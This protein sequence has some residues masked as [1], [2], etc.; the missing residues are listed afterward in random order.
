MGHL[1]IKPFKCTKCEF[2]TVTATNVRTH[3]RKS[4]LK[5][6]PYACDQC[7]KRFV[8]GVLL[9]EHL[10]THTG[11]RPFKCQICNFACASRQVLSCHKTTHKSNKVSRDI[12]INAFTFNYFQYLLLL[13]AHIIN[14]C[15]VFIILT[16]I[17]R[18][19]ILSQ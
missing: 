8:T 13:S 12:I 3:I 9:Q 7:E 15:V 1:D 10:N 5:I 18:I 19:I 17:F 4:H 6:K 14:I 2:A 11:A 16:Y